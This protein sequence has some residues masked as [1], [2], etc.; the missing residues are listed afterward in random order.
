MFHSPRAPITPERVDSGNMC[1]SRN[2]DI[3]SNENRR[4]KLDAGDVVDLEVASVDVMPPPALVGL[5]GVVA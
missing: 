3:L 1:L 4:V 2:A 5:R